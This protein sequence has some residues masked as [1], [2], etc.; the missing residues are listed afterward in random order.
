MI[1]GQIN[2]G[3]ICSYVL[4]LTTAGNQFGNNM[5]DDRVSMSTYNS[6]YIDN[7][8]FR[9]PANFRGVETVVNPAA[10]RDTY[11][12]EQYDHDYHE[13]F[14]MNAA[15]A[16]P[17]LPRPMTPRPTTPRPTTVTNVNYG[18]PAGIMGSTL[19]P[20]PT[21]PHYQDPDELASVSLLE[22]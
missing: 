20:E 15:R 5:I 19:P 22:A 18:V 21:S 14:E 3:L 11:Y 4:Y 7:Q 8:Q 16:L 6:Q 13:P 10:E 17:L 9:P 12:D 1:D 2:D